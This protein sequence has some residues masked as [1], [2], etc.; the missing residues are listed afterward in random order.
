MNKKLKAEFTTIYCYLAR[1]LTHNQ[2]THHLEEKIAEI[3]WRRNKDYKTLYGD[4][5]HLINF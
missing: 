4:L 2:N 5:I 1:K 3:L